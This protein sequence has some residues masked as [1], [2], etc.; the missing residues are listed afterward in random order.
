MAM[1]SRILVADDHEIVRKG[2]CAL[3]Q[4]GPGWGIC[5]EARDGFE[6][7]EKVEAC[8]P[9]VAI[10]DVKMPRLNGV[11]ATRE[12]RKRCPKTGVLV[13]TLYESERIIHSVLEAGARGFI[14]KTDAGRELVSAVD[15]LAHGGT[16]FTPKV[17]NTVLKGFLKDQ[18][19]A[20]WPA[21]TPREVEVVRLIAG[22]KTTKEVADLLGM[23]VKTAETHRGNVMRKLQLRSTG[24]LVLYAVRNE[25][26]R[27][28]EDAHD[29]S[30][31]A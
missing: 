30:I 28:P 7:I 13:L 10:L 25:I 11:E 18:R 20:S 16:Y 14:L 4:R 8:R 27:L 23:S 31:A 21:L 29:A 5:E 19:G 15:T 26:Y 1:S 6:A 12:I 9:Q 2:L 22:G 3:L 24:E 17:S